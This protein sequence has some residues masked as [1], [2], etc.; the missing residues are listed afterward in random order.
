MAH[1]RANGLI[2]DG[3]KKGLYDENSKKGGKWI[4]EISSVIR[5]LRTQPIK[6]TGQ[7]PFF[8]V[9]GFNLFY[10]QTSCG[11]LL[12][13]RCMTKARLITQDISNLIRLRKLDAMSCS[14]RP[15]TYKESTITT[16]GTVNNVLSTLEIWSFVA[17]KMEPGCTSLIRDGRDPSLC[18]RL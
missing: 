14:S 16:T 3:L 2:L 8:L 4:N 1:P 17:S 13:W 10:R 18:T 12:D 9:Y 7:L 6:A 5:G 15:A 11:N